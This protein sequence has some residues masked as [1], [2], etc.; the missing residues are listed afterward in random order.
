[1][2][3]T[4]APLYLTID[5]RDSCVVETRFHRDGLLIIIEVFPSPESPSRLLEVSFPH[6][7]G[8][9]VLDEGDM[10]S[11]LT[12]ECFRSGH[13]LYNITSGGWFSNL[14]SD[15]SLLQIASASCR[16]WLVVTANECVSIFSSAE[17]TV[18]EIQPQD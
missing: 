9:V 11:W 10:P 8:F 4:A 18:T 2:K 12:S 7:R 13:I 1:M 3:T 17:P 15:D 14:N 6:D 16:E 5:R